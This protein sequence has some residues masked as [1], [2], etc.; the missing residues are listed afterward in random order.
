MNIDKTYKLQEWARQCYQEEKGKL[1]GYD[2]EPCCN[3][4]RVR[5]EE[6]DNGP[7][8]C[9]KCGT[10]QETGELYENIYGSWNEFDD[11]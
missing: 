3:C 5:V 2:S 1:I 11:I 7:L 4:G 6:Y 8:I 9:E 10:D